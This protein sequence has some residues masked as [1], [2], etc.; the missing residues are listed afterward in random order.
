MTHEEET[1]ILRQRIKT[2]EDAIQQYLEIMAETG[3]RR[4]SAYQIMAKALI[5]DWN[6]AVLSDPDMT[7]EQ[8]ARWLTP[9]KQEG[10]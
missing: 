1:A 10:Q 5:V 9:K 2:L 3:Q 7:P 4:M 6:M 8:R